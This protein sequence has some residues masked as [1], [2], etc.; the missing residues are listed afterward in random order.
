MLDSQQYRHPLTAFAQVV[1]VEE[2][3]AAQQAVRES[4]CQPR[5]QKVHR[6]SRHGHAQHPDI[7]L[8][9]SPRGALALYRT[10]QARAAIVGRDYV[11]PDDVKALAE[12]TL[13]HRIIVG[14]KAR[15]KEISS[16]SI[17]QNIL[18]TVPVPGA[19]VG[20]RY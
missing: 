15:I 3:L 7:Y 19:T 11:I 14:P 13:A 17:V 20:T 6:G 16:R 9:A 4:V 1:T 2:L 18:N 12:A 8:G 10:S 5:H